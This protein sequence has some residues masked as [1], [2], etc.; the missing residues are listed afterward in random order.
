MLQCTYERKQ[1]VTII[2][3]EEEY[4]FR[5]WIWETPDKFDYARTKFENVVEVPNFFCK[6]PVKLGLGGKWKQV[7]YEEYIAAA[8]KTGISGHLHDSEDSY[9]IRLCVD[10][11]N[12]K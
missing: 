2:P 5:H 9:I 3:I 4:G 1:T 12:T 11:G 7:E 8:H 10:K 6:D